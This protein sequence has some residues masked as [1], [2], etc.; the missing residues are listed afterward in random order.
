MDASISRSEQVITEKENKKNQKI[1]SRGKYFE[2]DNITLISYSQYSDIDNGEA[3]VTTSPNGGLDNPI[4]AGEM[5]EIDQIQP[6][7]EQGKFN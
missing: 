6:R 4:I 7:N 2:R 1:E 3:S 5:I